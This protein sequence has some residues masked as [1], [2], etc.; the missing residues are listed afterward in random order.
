VTEDGKI[1]Y[2]KN[3]KCELPFL[4]K[5]IISFSG[6]RNVYLRDLGSKSV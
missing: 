3:P 4:G 5:K 1:F 6:I 2:L